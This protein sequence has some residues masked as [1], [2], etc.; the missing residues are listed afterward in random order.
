[1][2]MNSPGSWAKAFGTVFVCLIVLTIVLAIVDSFALFYLY[3]FTR[4]PKRWSNVSVFYAGPRKI[5]SGQGIAPGQTPVEWLVV[6]D[7]NGNPTYA[8][9]YELN[10]AD[11]KSSALHDCLLAAEDRRFYYHTGPCLTKLSEVRRITPD[12]VKF[13]T[14]FG[15]PTHLRVGVEKL[16]CTVMRNPYQSG[17]IQPRREVFT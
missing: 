3:S 10:L 8:I 9:Q 17:V 15:R 13:A 14:V 12:L 1:M 7:N 5:F 16:T 4:D 2:N 11:I 6:E